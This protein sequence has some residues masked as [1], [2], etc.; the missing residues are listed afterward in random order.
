MSLP[1]AV[2]GDGDGGDFDGVPDDCAA[3]TED[4][5]GSVTCT[6]HTG[7]M[8]EPGA[9]VAF[10][11]VPGFFVFF[12]LLVLALGI[13]GTIWRVSTARRMAR[14]S[15]LNVGDATA[16][17]LMDE[18]GLSATY[19]ASNLRQRPAP[20]PEGGLPAAPASTAARLRELS[21]LLQQGLITQAEHDE[22]RARIIDAV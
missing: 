6:Q 15:G 9:G 14:D 8:G 10:S 18:D 4:G 20:A 3:W 21:E 5:D 13:G 1:F 17:A 2:G 7:M 16:M 12:F 19:L 22:R 11:G